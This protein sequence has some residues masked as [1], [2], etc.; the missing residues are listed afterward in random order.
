MWTITSSGDAAF[1]EQIFISIAMVT[2]SGSFLRGASIAMLL[3]VLIM[4]FQSIV[5]G[6]QEFNIGAIFMGWILF[7]IM[8]VPTT[9]VLIEDKVSG[10]TRVVANVPFGVAAS[11][12]IISSIGYGLTELFE[13]GYH[14]IGA[15]GLTS[16]RFGESLEFLNRARSN[17]DNPRLIEAMNNA[18]SSQTDFRKSWDNYIRECTVRKIDLGF[19]SAE[20]VMSQSLPEA[21][22]F[23]SNIYMTEIYIGNAPQTVTCT[24]GYSI[25]AQATSQAL[26]SD[27]FNYALSRELNLFDEQNPGVPMGIAKVSNAI[28]N[29]GLMNTSAQKFMEASILAPLYEQAVIGRYQDMQDYSSALALNQAIAQRNTQWASEQSMF[30]KTV[31]PLQ[32]FFEGFVYGIT[33]ILAMLIITG[34][35]GFSMAGKYL[36]V[37]FWVQL[38]LPLLSIVNL[39]IL[40]SASGEIAAYDDPNLNSIYSIEGIHE[41]I[42]TW[43]GIG[44][45]LAASVPMIALFV[46]TGSTYAFTQIAGRLQGQDH[47]DEKM[48][49][50]SINAPAPLLQQDAYY[51]SD[52]AAGVRKSGT[53]SFFASSNIGKA[54]SAAES[55]AE[56]RAYQTGQQFS[57]ALHS[58]ALNS[59]SHAVSAGLS[60]ALSSGYSS[61]SGQMRSVMDSTAQS[62][63]RETGMS[64][65]QAKEVV[66]MAALGLAG[67]IGGNEF[68]AKIS[69]SGQFQDIDKNTFSQAYNMAQNILDKS[70]VSQ[71]ETL[72]F[73]DQVASFISAENSESFTQLSQSEIGRRLVQTA[74][75]HVTAQEQ[76]QQIQQ[77]TD[78]AGS[79]LDM[80]IYR[81]AANLNNEE[82]KNLSDFYTYHATPEQRQT[83]VD[84]A[85]YLEEATNMEPQLAQTTARLEALAIGNAATP[86]SSIYAANLLSK[87]AGLGDMLNIDPAQYKNLAGPSNEKGDVQ[88]KVESAL[89]SPSGGSNQAYQPATNLLGSS[90]VTG[91]Y[92]DNVSKVFDHT[93]SQESKHRQ[94]HDGVIDNVKSGHDQEIAQAANMAAPSQLKKTIGALEA[95]LNT[96]V[97]MVARWLGHDPDSD[98]KEALTPTQYEYVKLKHNYH[99]NPVGGI[100]GSHNPAEIENSLATARQAVIAEMGNE[101]SGKEMISLLDNFAV[102]THNEQKSLLPIIK[103]LNKSKEN[104]ESMGSYRDIN[105]PRG[106]INMLGGGYPTSSNQGEQQHMGQGGQ[107]PATLQQ[108]QQQQP[109]QPQQQQQQPQQQQPPQQAQQLQPP[110]EQQQSGVGQG[111]RLVSSEPVQAISQASLAVPNPASSNQSR[112]P[113][114]QPEVFALGAASAIGGG[115]I[116]GA[117]E[118]RTPEAPIP[119]GSDLP[120]SQQ[121]VFESPLNREN[122]TIGAGLN[123]KDS[124]SAQIGG[125]PDED[126]DKKMWYE[127]GPISKAW[128]E[129]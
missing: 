83:A 85:A 70:G 11:G 97:N 68:A 82:L 22:R 60:S 66:S 101:K 92:A 21:L 79:Q 54:L 94:A 40:S 74:T 69:G 23:D 29:L 49:T 38:W 58:A 31:R 6:A 25:I 55:S 61:T 118:Y 116:A 103:G 20:Q 39:Y 36:Q 15:S 63:S 13:Q 96:P 19:A 77:M 105:I 109:P 115:L 75:E 37:L 28:H 9:T 14:F 47:F 17:G 120:Q 45:M 126:S 87:A 18:I 81:A 110:V 128:Y 108:P 26:H 121:L 3:G 107:Q 1:L 34:S 30:M 106:E 16:S 113:A 59:S 78:S 50:P 95:A 111:V 7:M 27:S 99:S 10:S 123:Q 57:D 43:I 122:Q 67:G 127:R 5:R 24:E 56:Q 100:A 64:M 114:Q 91:Q 52:P 35:F 4:F 117:I 48:S 71:D 33:P 112:Q 119:L 93:R 46:V 89:R 88:N 73:Q 62:I 125:K 12:G 102:T 129:N 86:Q 90:H 124:P 80:P 42:Q 41:S 44:G 76:Y 104:I 98:V 8:F 65:S 2:G 51:A 72:A 84:R 32:T 53:E